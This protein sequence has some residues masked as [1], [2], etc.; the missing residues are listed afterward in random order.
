MMV[1][2]RSDRDVS[3]AHAGYVAGRYRDGVWSDGWTDVRR[4]AEAT[5][6]AYAPACGCGWRGP[7]V[8][9]TAKGFLSCQRMWVF[10]HAGHA[11][12]VGAAQLGESAVL[13]RWS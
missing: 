10:E 9:A 3:D 4:C 7:A 1:S 12:V 2:G 6:T 5:F 13:A 11:T 8:S